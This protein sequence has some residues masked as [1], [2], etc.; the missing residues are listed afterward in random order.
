MLS[1]AFG[2]WSGFLKKL[3]LIEG[4]TITPKDIERLAMMGTSWYGG[5]AMSGRLALVVRNLTQSMLSAPKVGFLNA[6][7]GVKAAINAGPEGRAELVKAGIINEP[8]MWSFAASRSSRLGGGIIQ[9]QGALSHKLAQVEQLTRSLQATGLSWYRGADQFNRAATYFAGKRALEHAW[10]KYQKGGAK[11]IETFYVDSGLAGDSKSFRRDIA[12]MLGRG[13]LEEAAHEYG[14][15]VSRITQ[16]LYSRPNVPQAFQGVKGRMFGQF[17]IWPLGFHS[18]VTEQAGGWVPLF[19]NPIWALEGAGRKALS[20]FGVTQRARTAQSRYRTKF[21]TRM[22]GQWVALGLM[23]RALGIDT[24]SWNKANPLALEG[25]PAFQILRDGLSLMIGAETEFDRAMGKASL[26]RFALQI[27]N[28]FAAAY[29]DV[30]DAIEEAAKGN[31]MEAILNA[32]GFNPR[33]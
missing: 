26:K 14:K 25:G 3:R 13:Q 23:G 5:L 15:H 30:E 10:A 4:D 12:R 18:Y 1:E 22:I 31:D 17:G 21:A 11:D 19:M 20:P 16:Y 27:M 9:A 8:A 33:I 28:P 24:S 32:L 7:R 29:R 2:Q 6:A